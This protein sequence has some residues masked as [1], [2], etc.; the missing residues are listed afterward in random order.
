MSTRALALVFVLGLATVGCSTTGRFVIPPGTQLEV[1]E[2][3][4]TPDASGQ[5]TTKP[6]FWTAAGVPPGAGIKYR[7]LKDGKVVKEGRL[8]AKFRVVSIFWPP[9][10]IIYWPMGL[11]PSITYDLVKDTQQ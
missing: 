10:A 9:L 7:L 5:V 11:N 3:P 2:R 1:Y 6:F 4:V 8:R